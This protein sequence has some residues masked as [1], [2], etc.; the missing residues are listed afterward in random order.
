MIFEVSSFPD[1]Q[2]SRTCVVGH[3]HFA[4]S[5]GRA[6]PCRAE[7]LAICL[8]TARNPIIPRSDC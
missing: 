3:P 4:T 7:T 6:L 1:V 5:V 8:I 2:Q